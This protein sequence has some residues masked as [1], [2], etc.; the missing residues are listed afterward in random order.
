MPPFRIP[1][2]RLCLWHSALTPLFTCDFWWIRFAYAQQVDT[3]AS[4]W[5]FWAALLVWPATAQLLGSN[6]Y[7]ATQISGNL[8]SLLFTHPVDCE[9]HLLPAVAAA[10]SVF[11]PKGYSVLEAVGIRSIWDCS[12]SL[13]ALTL[14]AGE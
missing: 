10:S 13:F 8:T 2:T 6:S 4:M 7:C 9:F 3:Q 1:V 5:I 12:Y 14:P 11:L